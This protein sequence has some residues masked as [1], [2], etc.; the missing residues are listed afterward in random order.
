MASQLDG[1]ESR[2]LGRLC[3]LPGENG[4]IAA[5]P[6]PGIDRIEARFSGAAFSMHRHDTYAI[7]LTM[8][9]VQ[10][11][12]YRGA[13][14]HSLP[15]QLIVLHPD[16]LHDGGAGTEEGLRY[17]M[18]YLEP[19]M[20]RHALS[21][22]RLGLPFVS[23]PV[24]S[25]TAMR[26]ALLSALGDI[27]DAID[28]L[29]ADHLIAA[30]ADGLSRHAGFRAGGRQP[31]P[32]FARVQRAREYLDAYALRSVQS[33][34]LEAVS[35]LD[36]FTLTRQFKTLFGTS[37][38]RYLIMR[39]LHYARRMLEAGEQLAEI[40]AATGFVDQSHFNR[41]FKKAFGMTPGNWKALV[42]PAPHS[43]PKG[44]S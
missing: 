40:A 11:F 23:D 28:G 1:N 17:R 12:W 44:A 3:E 26:Q 39:R 31:K 22:E 4:I 10:S 29:L 13:V 32:A 37:P 42:R 41:Q 7:G 2:G 18:L 19:S 6:Y 35:G 38:H 21:G 25:D 33:G 34:E 15:G 14:R 8:H 24:V 9:G 20:L 36:R 30:L 27:E 5:P 43:S 16:E